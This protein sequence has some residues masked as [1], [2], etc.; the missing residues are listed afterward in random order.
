M[1]VGGLMSGMDTE[2]IIR[3][4]MRVSR[5][6]LE[7]LNAEKEKLD[8]KKQVFGNVDDELTKLQKSLLDLRLESTFKSKIVASSDDRYVT[9]SA[10]VEAQ[11]GSHSIQITQIARS[12]IARSSY[13]RA[14]LNASP[15]NSAGIA[16]IVGRPSD[17]LNGT[18]DI[19]ISDEGSVFR[20]RSVFKPAGGG[21]MTTVE[22]S[23]AESATI[24]GSIG[25]SINAGNNGLTVTLNG[26][27][28]TVT[29]DD[30]TADVTSMARVAAD[31]ESKLNEA[32]NTALGTAD[33]TYVAARSSRDV[34]LGSDTIT[35]Y[36]ANGSG[37]ISVTNSGAATALGFSTGG[38]QGAATSIV[39]NVIASDLANLQIE[40]N[41][42]LTGIIKGVAFIADSDTGLQAGEAIVF[43]SSALNALGPSKSRIDGGASVS[44]GS[45]NTTVNGLQNAGFSNTPSTST[46]GSFTINGVEITIDD[47]T[48]LSVNDVLGIINGSAAGVTASYDAVNDRIVLTENEESGTRISLGDP[49][50][51]SDFLT[52][53]KL[54][55]NEGASSTIGS[56][57]S[58]VSAAS[59]LSS[60]GFTL[61]PT[62]GTFTIN[63]VTLYVDSSSDTLEDLIEKINNSGANVIASYDYQTDVFSL[64][65][66]MG[67]VTSNS[68]KITIGSVDDTSNILRALNLVDDNYAEISGGSAPLGD[69]GQ[70]TVTITPYGSS[71]GTDVTISATVGSA[72]YQETAGTVDWINGITDGATFTVLAGNT[73]SE[74]FTWT[75]NTGADIKSLDSFVA[76]WNDQS[77]WSGSRVEVGVIKEGP[78]KLRFFSL[79]A[80]ASGAN[81]DF[82]V[83]TTTA[84][85]LY[86]IGLAT[87]RASLSEN[88]TYGMAATASEQYNAMNLA[89]S[90]NIADVGVHAATD[91]AGG[92]TLTSTTTG[93]GA[94]FTLA[95]EATEADSTVL[96][97]FGASSVTA[98]LQ[99]NRE[100]GTAGQDS[101]FTVDGVS[102]T[103]SSNTV[104]DVIGGA[105][106]NLHAPT[107]TPVT[108]T[109]K[110]DTEKA[111]DKITDFIVNYNQIIS[112]INPDVLSDEQREYLDP[113]TNDQ[114]Y[115]MT[116][117]EIEDYEYYHELYSSWNFIRKES[118]FRAISSSIRQ[119]MTD[120]VEG[121]KPAMNLLSQIGISAGSI[122]GFE[123]SRDGYLIFSPSDGEEDY[124]AAIKE[125]LKLTSDLMT[126][127]EEDAES[128]Y[129]LFAREAEGS[130]EEGVARQLDQL[131]DDYIG[132]EGILDKKIRIGGSIDEEI[133]EIEDKIERLEYR[134]A[135]EE[136]RL[137]DDFTRMEIELNRLSESS[138]AIASLLGNTGEQ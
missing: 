94:G 15:D 137:W 4:L 95:D 62:S 119:I 7:N 102:Y 8:L 89:Y 46:N 84:G 22:G 44:G 130:G 35:L 91:G 42:P 93:Y 55:A 106:I 16:S 17:N 79:A 43:T 90:I 131:I 97:F 27:K 92:V 47:Y 126:A 99:E 58:N 33:I 111:L 125:S 25:T 136:E 37:D 45:L 19:S 20:A 109:I 9:A 117:T 28:V 129:E 81:A 108:I 82:T 67:E 104:D 14:V 69:R 5:L 118:S 127:L 76:A 60:A 115:D 87:D 18:H 30:A 51:T 73:G 72:A 135:E 116:Y 122:G 100:I 2:D 68:D 23:A 110:N 65:S 128:V 10:E 1:R 32:L 6:P 86:E 74:S 112:T 29:L 64:T 54:T 34:T 41:E 105:T 56:A 12:A 114:R 85:D 24:E 59:S 96:D 101:M 120:P 103:R 121:T 13:T 98:A 83:S 138:A 48:N 38:T 132:S 124:A 75:N 70:D 63:D 134:L 80:D 49:R 78:D 57:S 113:L 36:N 71:T 61:A 133:D 107:E 52:V 21:Q 40:M 26:E 31:V 88:I 39:T 123:D 77:N 3:Q 53:A 50:D 11:T 66:A